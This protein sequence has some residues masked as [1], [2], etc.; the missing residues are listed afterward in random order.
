MALKG[1]KVIELVGLAPGPFCGLLLKDFGAKV[2]RV[3][4][5]S[6]TPGCVPWPVIALVSL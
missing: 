2:L 6:R 5:V 4:N 3:D 1:V